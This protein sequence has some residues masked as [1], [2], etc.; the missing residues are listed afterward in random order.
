MEPLKPRKPKGSGPEA[1]IEQK[2]CQKLRN[3]GWVCIS[4]HGNE[5]QMGLPDIWAAHKRYGQRWIEVKNPA[6]YSFT[7][8]QREVFP[9]MASVEV[10]IW[11]LT[12]DDDYEI[13]KLFGPPNWWSYWK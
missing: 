3:L 8:A 1:I 4:T 7:N 2:I 10:G 13:N 11:I 5:Y 12:S 6:G 9:Q